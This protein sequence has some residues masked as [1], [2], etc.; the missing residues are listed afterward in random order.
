MTARDRKTTCNIIRDLLNINDE[1]FIKQCEESIFQLDG[2]Y[3]QNT[4]ERIG[5]L[6]L[7]SK[8]YKPKKMMREII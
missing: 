5:E 3:K 2:D 6:D 4:Y 7:I 1:K 8:K